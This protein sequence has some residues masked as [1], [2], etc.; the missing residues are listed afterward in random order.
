LTQ[1]NYHEV[2]HK[3]KETLHYGRWKKNECVRGW[4]LSEG[5][6]VAVCADPDAS[7]PQD[8]AKRFAV[9]WNP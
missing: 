8:R 9:N 5:R 4:G 7:T 1:A 2:L 3:R 6:C